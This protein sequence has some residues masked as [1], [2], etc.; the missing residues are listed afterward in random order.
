LACQG[1]VLDQLQA[2]AGIPGFAFGLRLRS[3][4]YAV[5]RRRGLACPGVV[6]DQGVALKGRSG[7][8]AS[9]LRRDKS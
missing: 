9:Q 3:R 7:F 4:S 2:S 1:V 8:A 5:T 6:L